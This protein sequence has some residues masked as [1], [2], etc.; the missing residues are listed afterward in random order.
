MI[1]YQRHHIAV[2]ATPPR[3]ATGTIVISGEI[4]AGRVPRAETMRSHGPALARPPEKRGFPDEQIEPR[5]VTMSLPSRG[6]AARSVF[7][8]ADKG[9]DLIQSYRVHRGIGL[10]ANK[11]PLLS[12]A[13]TYL[14]AN[15][16]S[17]GSRERVEVSLHSVV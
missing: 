1:S 11:S 8:F 10:S 14:T 9:H 3:P 2:T 12:V 7:K 4:V 17:H 13:A 15:K 16:R 6:L 5:R